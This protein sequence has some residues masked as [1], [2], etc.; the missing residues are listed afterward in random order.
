VHGL[1]TRDG[2]PEHRAQRGLCHIWC[3]L[4]LPV[5]SFRKMRFRLFHEDLGFTVSR[6]NCGSL[7]FLCGG[8]LQYPDMGDLDCTD[9]ETTSKL[10][11]APT[12][13]MHAPMIAK[14]DIN[15]SVAYSR[16][17]SSQLSTSSIAPSLSCPLGA[18]SLSWTWTTHLPCTLWTASRQLR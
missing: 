1:C 17:S 4:D 13:N 16:P 10:H 8:V 11:S 15:S 3:V 7:E 12:P 2:G 14:S 9:T 18:G 6:Q 5:D